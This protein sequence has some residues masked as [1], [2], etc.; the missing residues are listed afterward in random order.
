MALLSKFGVSKDQRSPFLRELNNVE[1][2]LH[3][4]YDE[5]PTTDGLE[6]EIDDISDP[7]DVDGRSSGAGDLEMLAEAVE[8][9]TETDNSSCR[10]TFESSASSDKT[11]GDGT[12]KSDSPKS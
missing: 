6:Q 4:F 1:E 10:G 7:S 5:G 3:L 11:T 2:L 12:E 8:I 9:A